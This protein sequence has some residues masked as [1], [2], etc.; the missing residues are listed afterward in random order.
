MEGRT[1]RN[2][3]TGSREWKWPEIVYQNLDHRRRRLTP[4]DRLVV[5]VGYDPDS[6]YPPGVDQFAHAWAVRHRDD[7][8]PLFAAVDVETFPADWQGPCR[9]ECRHKPRGEGA[10]CPAAGMYRNGAMVASRPD[11]A[12]AFILDRSRGASA[13]LNLIEEAGINHL[14]LRAYTPPS[15]PAC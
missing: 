2:L 7:P 3:I 14:A 11:F 10:R 13:C 1:E 9:P 8:H 6:Q 5:V 12:L 4:H 15:R